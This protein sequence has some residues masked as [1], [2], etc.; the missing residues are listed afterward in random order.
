[1]SGKCITR[2]GECDSQRLADQVRAGPEGARIA[3]AASRLFLLRLFL[4]LGRSGTL[5]SLLILALLL[6]FDG[7]EVRSGF[8]L[9]LLDHFL[10]QRDNLFRIPSPA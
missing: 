1:M 6:H 3:L 9:L 8:L 4:R 7:R 10:H 5:S 2:R